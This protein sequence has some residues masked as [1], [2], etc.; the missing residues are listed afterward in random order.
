VDVAV[1]GA[2]F[3]LALFAPVFYGGSALLNG[4]TSDAPW[5]LILGVFGAAGVG[6][7]LHV[8]GEA[9]WEFFTPYG[10]KSGWRILAPRVHDFRDELADGEFSGKEPKEKLFKEARDTIAKVDADGRTRSWWPG[11]ERL[12]A[13]EFSFYRDAPDPILQ[14]CRRRYGRFTDALTASAAIVLGVVIGWY[15]LTPYDDLGNL[16][17][18]DAILLVVVVVTMAWAVEVRHQAQEMER[19]WFA[20]EATKEEPKDPALQVKFDKERPLVVHPDGEGASRTWAAAELLGRI[21][22]IIGTGGQR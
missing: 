11:H 21:G 10:S 9:L 7:L 4:V 6:A 18:F 20:V 12:V 15:F 16:V 1:L 14:W 17:R 19:F 2:M 5:F 13:T 22:E 3:L 8:T